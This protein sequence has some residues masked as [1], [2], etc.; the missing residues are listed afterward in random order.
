MCEIRLFPCKW[1]QTKQTAMELI[2]LNWSEQVFV[3]YKALDSN[4]VCV[5]MHV[6]THRSVW[7]FC[8]NWKNNTVIHSSY[9]TTTDTEPLAYLAASQI[10]ISCFSILCKLSPKTD[11]RLFCLLP[12]QR[13]DQTWVNVKIILSSFQSTD[14]NK[15]LFLSRKRKKWHVGRL[16]YRQTQNFPWWKKD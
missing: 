2:G 9:I 5:C 12:Q 1:C 15:W 3:V 16:H 8:A 7:F 6:C 4:S 13:S 10:Q 11:I 14:R